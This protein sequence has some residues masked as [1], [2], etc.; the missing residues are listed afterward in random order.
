MSKIVTTSELQKKIV[1]LTSY[2]EKDFIIVTSRGKA[3]V[4]ILPYFEDND[5]AISDYLETYEMKNNEKN[6]KARYREA[7][8]SQDS[9]LVI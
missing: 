8:Q 2:P 6:L 5:E 4:V 7:S 1:Q 9:D 3:K